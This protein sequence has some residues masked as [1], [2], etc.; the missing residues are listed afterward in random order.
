MLLTRLTF[1]FNESSVIFGANFGFQLYRCHYWKCSSHF[2]Q[3]FFRWSTYDLWR[4]SKI[5]ETANIRNDKCRLVVTS[6]S[7]GRF[8]FINCQSFTFALYCFSF[9]FLS[10]L[11]L[12]FYF[13]F[14]SFFYNFFSLWRILYFSRVPFLALGWS[15]SSFEAF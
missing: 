14:S 15:E 10:T 6:H 5:P 3:L 9:N 4:E 8:T 12:F 7:R 2:R 13:F 1:C 11:S